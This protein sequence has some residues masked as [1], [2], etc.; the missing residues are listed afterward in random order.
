MPQPRKPTAIRMIHGDKANRFNHDEPV[1]PE[2]ALTCPEGVTD[3]VRDIWD[4]TVDCLEQMGVADPS[5]RDTL[6][7]YCEAVAAH[8]QASAVLAQS[9]VIIKGLHGGLVRNPAL[10]VQEHSAVLI[11]ALGAQFGLTPSSRSGIVVGGT[12]QSN[13]SAERL[14]S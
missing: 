11:R 1:A 5:G 12:K 2:G 4:Y 7:C 3:V 10:V 9:S 13:V 6:L 8:R 14:L